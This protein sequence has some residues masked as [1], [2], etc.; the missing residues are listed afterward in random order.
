MFQ[1]KIERRKRGRIGEKTEQESTS[2][3]LMEEKQEEQEENMAQK[4]NEKQPTMI[5]KEES[6]KSAKTGA[7][8]E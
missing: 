3:G 6:Q 1:R 2:N 4:S 8:R 7:K 5:Q